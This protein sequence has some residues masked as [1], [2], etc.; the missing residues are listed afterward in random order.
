MI[1]GH[2]TVKVNCCGCDGSRKAST[3]GV[4]TKKFGK[5]RTWQEEALIL[6]SLYWS[7]AYPFVC[8]LFGSVVEGGCSNSDKRGLGAQLAEVRDAVLNNGSEGGCREQGTEASE[9]CTQACV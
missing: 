9:R 7:K 8:A 3:H 5:R 6:G 1:Y 4:D 2:L